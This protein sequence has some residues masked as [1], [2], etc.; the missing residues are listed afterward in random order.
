MNGRVLLAALLG[1]ALP[2]TGLALPSVEELASSKG[3]FTLTADE[4]LYDESRDVYE[5]I[6]DVR[7]VQTAGRVVSADW[8]VFNA[9]TGVGVATGDVRLDDSGESSVRADFV[10]LD[11]NS[12]A[13]FATDA[14]LESKAPSLVVRGRS[15]QRTGSD[16]YKVDR[17][18]LSTT[19]STR[20]KM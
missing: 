19:F 4:V 17:A 15:I 1:C 12:T 6:G 2:Q 13:A 9:T 11:L 14:V 10:A 7:I 8:M 3:G 5:A 20:A 18:N 16:R